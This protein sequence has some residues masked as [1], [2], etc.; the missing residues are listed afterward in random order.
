M[1]VSSGPRR[2][3][4][5]SYFEV[6]PNIVVF[7]ADALGD[8]RSVCQI[9]F[10]LD[11]LETFFHY[12]LVEYHNLY[13]ADGAA[14]EML[15]TLRKIASDRENYP[16]ELGDYDFADA[17]EVYFIHNAPDIRFKALNLEYQIYLSRCGLFPGRLNATVD[18]KAMITISFP[19]P[20][21]LEAALDAVWCC[22]R[23]FNQ[24][25]FEELNVT[26]ISVSG[27]LGPQ[28]KHADL[29][30]SNHSR[31]EP[32]KRGR[33][34][35]QPGD[36][37][38]NSWREKDRFVSLFKNWLEA[39]ADRERFR[40]FVDHV[41]C[42]FGKSYSPFQVGQLC[43]AI[44]SLIIGENDKKISDVLPS[45]AEAAHS[46]ASA[47][48]VDLTVERIRGALG[49]IANPPLRD[50]LNQL[51]ENELAATDEKKRATFWKNIRK[52]RSISAHGGR[53]VDLVDRHLLPTIQAF[54][55]LCILYEMSN[56]GMKKSDLDGSKNFLIAFREFRYGMM[57]LDCNPENQ[58]S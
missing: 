47:Q 30:L 4:R 16:R 44:D 12:E 25:A 35:L 26:A 46:A 54:L 43:A 2:P 55:G 36:L 41:L 32:R 57:C 34:S 53:S 28:A 23:F 31:P 20:F 7:D 40:I 37:P 18:H 51:F 38:F 11:R 45:M 22:K 24:L 27:S 52:Y 21:S 6:F 33:Y 19:E 5:A 3:E 49:L 13:G 8:S 48:G 42:S 14:D 29:Y 50:R 15:R 10:C 58:K 56:A 1:R 39:D 17:D 9:S